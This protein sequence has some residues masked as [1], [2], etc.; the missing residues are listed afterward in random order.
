MTWG[1]NNIP[2]PWFVGQEVH[3]P[4]EIQGHYV[5]PSY[6][7]PHYWE[8]LARW[9]AEESL[10]PCW[11]H[12]SKVLGLSSARPAYLHWQ[13]H[14]ESSRVLWF[15]VVHQQETSQMGIEVLSSLWQ[16]NWILLQLSDLHRGSRTSTRMR[17]RMMAW[18]WECAQGWCQGCSQDC[19]AAYEIT[20]WTA[21]RIVCWQFL[22]IW[23]SVQGP[24]W[25]PNCSLWYLSGQLKRC[26]KALQGHQSLQED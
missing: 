16:H 5:G 12:A 24:L 7:W 18:L 26:A 21:V 20:C 22:Y 3:V 8:G 19:Y 17:T 10:V 15:Q 11:F 9:Q 25:T 23:A 6:W 2:L 1:E 13:M 14:G 4:E